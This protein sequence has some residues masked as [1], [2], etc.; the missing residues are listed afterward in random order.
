[1]R[2]GRCLRLA[3]EAGRGCRNG[4]FGL[5]IA[6]SYFQASNNLIARSIVLTT[7]RSGAL[8]G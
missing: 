8:Y 2:A 4:W 1:M 6:G 5:R 3:Y 7:S